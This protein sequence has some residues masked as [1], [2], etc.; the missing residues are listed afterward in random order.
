MTRTFTDENFQREIQATDKPVLVDFWAE[1]CGPCRTLA[2][3]LEELSEE[4]G[5]DAVVGKV[6]V[7]EQ[8]R[9]AAQFSIRSIPTVAVFVGG[10]PV[11]ALVGVQPK[12]AYL[13]AIDRANA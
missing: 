2:P 9:L 1:W 3:V 10:K 7:D 4:L 5:D 12:A 13:A 11:E 6:N 8:S